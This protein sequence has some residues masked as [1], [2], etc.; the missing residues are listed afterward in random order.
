[1]TTIVEILLMDMYTFFNLFWYFLEKAGK[2]VYE[3]H[4]AVRMETVERVTGI[5]RVVY[6]KLLE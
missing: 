4:A 3:R 2:K 1:M 5:R 6:I